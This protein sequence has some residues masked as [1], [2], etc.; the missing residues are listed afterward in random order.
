M[1][2][3]CCNRSLASLL[4][5]RRWVR[6]SGDLAGTVGST[7]S[8]F[9][10]DAPGQT[11][12]EIIRA[13]GALT[14]VPVD[15]EV[16][17]LV[18]SQQPPVPVERPVPTTGYTREIPVGPRQPVSL[19]AVKP[20]GLNGIFVTFKDQRWFSHGPAVTLESSRLTQTGTYQGLP[21]YVDLSAPNTIYV[22]VAASTPSLVAPYT[23][24]DR[25]QPV[26]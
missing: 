16:R 19:S 21:V 23:L 20:E 25:P 11:S 1:E 10:I 3:A 9:P 12:Y 15:R 6:R 17:A 2:T 5:S 13:Q 22:P 18:G 24:G 8:S 26:R 4:R 7:V 14:Y